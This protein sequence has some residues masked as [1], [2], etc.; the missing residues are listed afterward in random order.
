MCHIETLFGID[1]RQAM[2]TS[3]VLDRNKGGKGLLMYYVFM[4]LDIAKIFD[5]HVERSL[6]SHR[7]IIVDGDGT[8]DKQCKNT[9][10]GENILDLS[11]FFSTVIDS[12][13]FCLG[14]TLGSVR[15]VFGGPMNRVTHT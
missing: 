3:N 5:C 2:G 15:F 11:E 14:G 7:F 12:P 6:D 4:H 13:N 1:I 8:G 9:K 10:V